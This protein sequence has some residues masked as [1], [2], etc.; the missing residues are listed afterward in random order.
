MLN[1]WKRN[2]NRTTTHLHRHDSPVGEV[3]RVTGRIAPGQTG[4]V[5]VR[6]RGGS[7]AFHAFADGGV[8]IERGEQVLVVEYIPPRN[9]Y[10]TRMS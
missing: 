4:E 5:M 6:I 2:W 9:V 10:V 7:E 3:A 8:T 1:Q